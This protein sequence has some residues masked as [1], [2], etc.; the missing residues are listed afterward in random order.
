M[1]LSQRVA[2]LEAIIARYEAFFTFGRNDEDTVPYVM[3]Q[4]RLGIMTDYWC[5][6]PIGQGAGLSV[7]TAIDRFAGYFEIDG[8]SC[9]THPS[10]AVY[11]AV[12]A[13]NPTQQ[14][15]AFEAHA[16]NA[17][18][19]NMAYYGDVQYAPQHQPPLTPIEIGEMVNGQITHTTTIGFD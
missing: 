6:Q 1:T 16:Q 12:V 3:T 19:G 18:H 7:G 14:N 10:T 4:G 8:V 5:R 13:S 9:P 2:R 11:G 17:P 15:L